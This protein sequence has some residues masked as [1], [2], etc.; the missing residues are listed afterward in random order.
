MVGH[1]YPNEVPTDTVKGWFEVHI[2]YVERYT[3]YS[4]EYTHIKYYIMMSEV[5]EID[6]FLVTNYIST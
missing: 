5:I 6:T 3:E 4:C 1:N 2:V